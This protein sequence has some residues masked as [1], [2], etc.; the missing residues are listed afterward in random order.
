MSGPAAPLHLR[1]RHG[2]SLAAWHMI[3]AR[4][5]LAALGSFRR[6]CGPPA[7][8]MI[9]RSS[10]WKMSLS[11]GNP[12]RLGSKSVEAIVIRRVVTSD[13]ERIRAVR[14]R[15]LATDPSS[16]ASTYAKEAAYPDAEWIAWATGDAGGEEMATML[17]LEGENAV[18]LVGA[19]R[20]EGNG[21]LY[22]VIAMWVAPEHRGS[23]VGRRLLTAIEEWIARA[24]GTTV[25]LDVADTAKVAVSL[26]ESSGYV[27]DGQQSLS[28]HTAGVTHLSLRKLLT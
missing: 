14:L 8:A 6:H 10:P 20:D 7:L 27:P 5:R 1:A 28:P 9:A 17:A 19:Y 2:K 26:Y 11:P 21:S 4:D 23:G 18:G 24:G 25:Q 13:A 12:C 15:A 16:F 3:P 22:H